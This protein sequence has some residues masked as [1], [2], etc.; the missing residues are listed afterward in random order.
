VILS[1][2]YLSEFSNNNGRY[3]MHNLEHYG[4]NKLTDNIGILFDDL[5]IFESYLEENL[6]NDSEIASLDSTIS[7]R[8]KGR[9]YFEKKYLGTGIAK[10]DK[11]KSDTATRTILLKNEYYKFKYELIK[12]IMGSISICKPEYE[13]ELGIGFISQTG[14]TS[15]AVELIF[16]LRITEAFRT[17][18]IQKIEVDAPYNT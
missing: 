5:K 12:R 1:N 7:K 9:W 4:N 3:L 18:H 2:K 8:I 16:N 13:P 10:I 6:N 14:M 11:N 15:D 17:N